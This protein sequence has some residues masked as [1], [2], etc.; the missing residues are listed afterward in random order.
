MHKNE[1]GMVPNKIIKVDDSTVGLILG[2]AFDSEKQNVS[3]E[4]EKF[5]IQSQ[6]RAIMNIELREPLSVITDIGKKETL[7]IKNRFSDF[8]QKAVSNYF[9]GEVTHI[10]EGFFV[11]FSSVENA[12]KCA[13]EIHHELKL[14]NAE[15][16]LFKLNA[17][18][19]LDICAPVLLTDY[20]GDSIR[21]TKRLCS[22]SKGGGILLSSAVRAADINLSKETSDTDSIKILSPA[23]EEFLNRLIDLIERVWNDA[24]FNLDKFGREMGMSK[25]QL[26]R[27]VTSLTGSSPNVFLR[28]Y[29]LKKAVSM[30]NTM[31]GNISEIAFESGF[32]NPSYFSK[33]FHNKFGIL[34]SE[35]SNKI[36]S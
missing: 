15:S 25:A 36:A 1:H 14:Y 8:M 33:C 13:V 22:I 3:D 35:Y 21:L 32:G 30:I 26:Y 34:P 18:I 5:I 19:G 16:R 11:T 9:G 20:S 17:A 27:K 24:S 6:Y 7:K 4:N 10:P 31:K 12:V 2:R 28:N 29:R 23:E